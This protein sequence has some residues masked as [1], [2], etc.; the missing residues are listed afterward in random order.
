MDDKK[1]N[2]LFTEE[3]IKTRIAELGKVLTEEYKDKKLYVLPLLRG[4]FVFGAD[5]FRAIDC[6]AKVGL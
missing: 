6:R 4:S 1:R 5:L 3:Q 2:I